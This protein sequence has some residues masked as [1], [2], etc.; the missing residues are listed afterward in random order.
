MKNAGSISHDKNVK[1]F[2]ESTD[3][4]Y[5][6]CFMH[7]EYDTVA[8]QDQYFPTLINFKVQVTWPRNPMFTFYD[9]YQLTF[10]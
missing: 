10:L 1:L 9:L 2:Y 5:Y 4:Q 8:A 6:G 7:N 3:D